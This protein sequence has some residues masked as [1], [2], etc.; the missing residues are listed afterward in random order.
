M[1]RNLIVSNEQTQT[2]SS[3]VIVANLA[4][5]PGGVEVNVDDVTENYPGGVVYDAEDGTYYPRVL[6]AGHIVY[7]EKLGTSALQCYDGEYTSVAEVYYGSPGVFGVVTADAPVYYDK[8]RD[9]YYAI[10]SVMIGGVV[11]AAQMPG[12][13]YKVILDP[14]G[15]II[16]VN[17]PAHQC[18]ITFLNVDAE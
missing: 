10:C 8:E 2:P 11:D 5:L 13:L 17:S 9:G 1:A 12:R 4:A 14:L 3:P 18:N 15:K 6:K 16:E 7:V